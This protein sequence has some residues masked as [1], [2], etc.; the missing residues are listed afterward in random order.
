[1]NHS[2]QTGLSEG[3][4]H[5]LSV[6]HNGD[7]TNIISLIGSLGGSGAVQSASTPLSISG[8][9]LSVDLSSYITSSA[10]NALLAQYRLTASL[11]SGVTVGAGLVSVAGNGVLSLGLTGT[12]SRSAL[13]LIDSQGDTLRPCLRP[14]IPK[15]MFM[16]TAWRLRYAI[17]PKLH[18]DKFP[19][20]ENNDFL[21]LLFAGFMFLGWK[22]FTMPR[23]FG[24]E[25]C[26]S[27]L[28]QAPSLQPHG[29]RL[30]VLLSRTAMYTSRLQMP[31]SKH[32]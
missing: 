3:D 22:P 14:R 1:M 13:S 28:C 8:G 32:F 2:V 17:F 6:L 4:F 20:L 9:V 27:H 24:A 30:L 12:E 25:L 15:F 16:K 10:V 26:R 21:V 29:I 5:R 18:N 31:C 23:N 19:I 11:F 7:M